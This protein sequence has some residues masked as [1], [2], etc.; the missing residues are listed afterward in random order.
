MNKSG[1][2]NLVEKI[3]LDL[4]KQ[5]FENN[6]KNLT[7]NIKKLTEEFKIKSGN[8]YFRKFITCPDDYNIGINA[9]HL[10]C[11]TSKVKLKLVP[12]FEEDDDDIKKIEA[13]AYSKISECIQDKVKECSREIYQPKKS[14]E[15][16]NT[17]EDDFIQNSIMNFDDMEIEIKDSD[18]LEEGTASD[19]S[20]KYDI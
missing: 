8:T 11:N 15:L 19:F 10:L 4:I 1:I 9:F 6:D 14:R 13:K 16:P 12:Y 3:D 2:G 17:I 5:S 20:T 18:E 7:L